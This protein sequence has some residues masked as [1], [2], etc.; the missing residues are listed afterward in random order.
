MRPDPSGAGEVSGARDD[1]KKAVNVARDDGKEKG[2]RSG[3]FDAEYRRSGVGIVLDIVV[4]LGAVDV[5][6]LE[7][8]V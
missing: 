8:K 6:G 5:V 2:K 4:G 1:E 7:V 3:T